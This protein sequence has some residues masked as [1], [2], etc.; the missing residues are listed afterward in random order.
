MERRMGFFT[1][2]VALSVTM[3]VTAALPGTP[4]AAAGGSMSSAN[5]AISKS[6]LTGG[7]TTMGS[8]SYAMSGVIAQSI[9]GRAQSA[10]HGLSSGFYP[11]PCSPAPV[12]VT[13]T[14]TGSDTIRLSWAHV[15]DNLVYE[16]HR[17]SVPH[18]QPVPSSGPGSTLLARVVAPPWQFEDTEGG[19]VGDPSR[20]YFYAVRGVCIGAHADDDGTGEFDFAI[21]PGS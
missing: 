19:I 13:I 2:A 1:A 16:V 18:F 20:N 3:V 11:P 4:V 14:R 15:E 21:V 8:P 7:G 17:S 9:I 5:F 6:L 10:N 12:E